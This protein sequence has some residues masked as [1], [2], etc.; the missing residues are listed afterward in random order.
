MDGQ[1]MHGHWV[2]AARPNYSHN[3]SHMVTRH[4]TVQHVFIDSDRFAKIIRP[5]AVLCIFVQTILG[6]YEL[7]SLQRPFDASNQLALVWQIVDS[8]PAALPPETPN[9]IVD[10][11]R[12]LLQKDPCET[13]CFRSFR[14]L[15]K[16][17]FGDLP[18]WLKSPMSKGTT[19]AFRGFGLHYGGMQRCSKT[20]YQ[21][22]SRKEIVCVKQQ[23]DSIYNSE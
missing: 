7:A 3:F 16:D 11:I 15:P 18:K 21:A 6:L 22:V 20:G 9:D 10:I 13:E 14:R 8:Q 2:F 19:I 17:V 23:Y 1:Q 12:G 4:C 5:A